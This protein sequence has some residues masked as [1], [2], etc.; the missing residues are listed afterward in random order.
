MRELIDTLRDMETALMNK[1]EA[2]PETT[3]RFYILGQ[4]NGIQTAIKELMNKI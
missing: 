4:V 3:E 1:Y 2:E